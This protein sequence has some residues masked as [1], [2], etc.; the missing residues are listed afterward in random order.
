MTVQNH[1]LL[2]KRTMSELSAY[3]KTE[4]EQQGS[5][6]QVNLYFNAYVV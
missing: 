6:R 2:H 1:F 3:H 4:T 5:S